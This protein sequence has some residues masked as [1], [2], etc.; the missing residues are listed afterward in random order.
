MK[1]ID[2]YKYCFPNLWKTAD[3]FL[4]NTKFI[5]EFSNYFVFKIPEWTMLIAVIVN[6]INIFF[7]FKNYKKKW[8]Y[9]L[10]LVLSIIC[11]ILLLDYYSI[12]NYDDV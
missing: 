11:S 3:S 7:G 5:K 10:I 1:A 4:F 12:Y 6:V 2:S 8:W 9:Y